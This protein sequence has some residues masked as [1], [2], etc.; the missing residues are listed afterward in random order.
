[1]TYL[2][3]KPK[4][5]IKLGELEGLEPSTTAFGAVRSNHLAYSSNLVLVRN[6]HQKS[7]LF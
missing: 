7:V 2:V 4:S 3:H 6:E 5:G 1:M